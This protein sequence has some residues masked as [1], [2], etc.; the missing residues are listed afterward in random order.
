ML[1]ASQATVRTM[2]T[3]LL[4]RANAVLQNAEQ[5]S[6]RVG[7]LL[8]SSQ[9]AVWSLQFQVLPGA[10]KAM[11]GVDR[12]SSNL[13]ATV[14]RIRRDPSL[15]LRGSAAVLGPGETP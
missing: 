7:P 2:Q 8:L 1:Q 5:A 14:V 12:L 6:A 9:D 3:Q 4:P 15:L 10:E 11:A 13:D